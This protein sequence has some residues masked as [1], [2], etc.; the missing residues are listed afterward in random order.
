MYSSYLSSSEATKVARS[1]GLVMRSRSSSSRSTAALMCVERL[2]EV[3][4]VALDEGQVLSA[5]PAPR[6]AHG[7]SGE[8]SAPRSGW[9]TR[10]R[11]G[12]AA[13]ACRPIA[14][15]D[16]A[17][18]GRS[19]QAAADRQ[20]VLLILQRG[21]VVAEREVRLADGVERSRLVFLAADLRAR[22]PAPPA[23]G[24]DASRSWPSR[25]CRVPAL[26]RTRRGLEVLDHQ[27]R[28]PAPAGT[29]PAPCR[30]PRRSCRQC[31]CCSA[32]PADWDRCGG[33]RSSA[34]PRTARGHDRCRRCARRSARCR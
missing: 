20:R 25:R 22:C 11:Y 5:C 28:T 30:T 18:P 3:A 34:T 26:M 10:D 12:R 32:S 8:S 19:R 21:V 6:I 9:R 29:R 15:S 7:C 31:R 13:G 24:P 33:D 4:A 1:S 2:R 16:A 17:W 14:S 27:V 23:A